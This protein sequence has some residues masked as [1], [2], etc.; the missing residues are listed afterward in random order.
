MAAAAG[1]QDQAVASTG[2]MSRIT[3]QMMGT[4]IQTMMSATGMEALGTTTG[5]STEGKVLFILLA[6]CSSCSAHDL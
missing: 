2:G 6:S 1:L 3:G 5:Q 4:L